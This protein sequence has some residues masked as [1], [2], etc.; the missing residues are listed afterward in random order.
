MLPVWICLC[1]LLTSC[2]EM[3][4]HQPLMPKLDKAEAKELAQP[5]DSVPKS[6]RVR[7][8]KKK[9][10]P[11]FPKTM[12][13]QVSITVSEGIPLKN[14]FIELARQAEVDLQLDPSIEA[15][16]IF[17]AQ[18]RPFIE[19][20]KAMCEMANLRFDV[21]DHALRIERDTPYSYNYNV[22]FLNL[23]R[24]SENQLTVATDF[25]SSV[26]PAKGNASDNV[27]KSALKATTK[28]DFWDELEQNLK[29]L[30]ESSSATGS[31]KGS[32]A[33]HRQAG[34]VFLRANRKQHNL[35]AQYLEQLRKVAC[36]QVLIEAKIIEVTLKDEYRSG[37]NWQ[38]I[39]TKDDLTVTANFGN[40]AKKSSF[41]DPTAAQ[42]DMIS[43]GASGARFSAIAN[44]LQEFGLVRTLSSP[45]LT[46]MNNQAAILK[47]AQN[48]VYFRLNYDKMYN[49]Q[50]NRESTTVSSDIQTVP[51]GLIMMVQPSIDPE[52]GE[53]ILFLRPSISR[54][55]QSVAD[56]AVDIAYNASVTAG[57]DKTK[58]PTQSMI[59]VVEVREIDSVL[60]LNNGEM[61][62]LGGLM[63]VRSSEHRQGIPGLDEVPLLRDLTGSIAEGD[64]IV[65]LVI[66]LKATIVDNGAA[67]DGADQR[68]M[69]DYTTDPRPLS[70]P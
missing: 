60:R 49:S 27:S 1:L 23:S 36:C 51:I 10:M 48:K 47:V 30:V 63:E 20:I 58:S 40:L 2:R 15:K 67:P 24:S 54:L 68:L 13:T 31:E 65:E 41:L 4:N 38:R 56:P 17:T 39:G 57:A 8:D 12:Y 7:L 28:N 43:F 62:I 55:T 5:A 35:V 42:A 44:V 19:I 66:V 11:K 26:G 50:N 45:R 21:I 22:Q 37:I 25:F 33:I 53:I 9:T 32:Y 61:A 3:S 34:L 6:I 18:K 59:P 64:T 46:V 52:T 29:T 70:T 16:I 14:I 69:S